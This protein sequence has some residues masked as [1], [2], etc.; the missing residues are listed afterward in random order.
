MASLT[1][2]PT[3]AGS[4]VDGDAP[5]AVTTAPSALASV[6]TWE[7]VLVSLLGIAL[8]LPLLGSYSLWD[9][10]EGHYG[11]VARRM[12]EDHDW[13]VTRWQD[14]VFRSKP[15]L[16]FWL[17]GLS[18]SAFGVARDGGFSGEFLT[19]HTMEF[20]LRLPFALFGVGAL[21]FLWYTLARLVS[22]RTAWLG[23]LVCA[24]SPYY[25]FVT[26]QAITDMPM[27]AMCVIG[28]GLFALTVHEPG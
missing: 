4:P 15:P 28:L 1:S 27:C 11:E 17:M 21:I 8:F 13:V 26:R 10:W 5:V 12:L 19:S 6:R 18:M 14:E 23:A 25:F 3:L 9:P 20:A 7:V 24:T 22:R 2:A 16:T